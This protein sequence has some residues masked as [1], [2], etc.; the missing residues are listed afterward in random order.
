MGAPLQLAPSLP[1]ATRRAEELSQ[2]QDHCMHLEKIKKNYEV[3]IKG[4]QAKMEEAEQLA[5]KGGKR[6]IM[7]LEARIKELETEL[8][9]EQKQHVE[10]VKTLRKNERRL[11]ELVFQTEDHK[12]NQRMQELVE[13]LQD[14]LKVYKRQIEE[15][16]GACRAARFCLPPQPRSPW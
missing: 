8:D 16:V 12:T 1:Q 9:G 5:L 11:K 4:L 2:E 7:K 13:K 6:T 14:K 3:T 10:T 15:A